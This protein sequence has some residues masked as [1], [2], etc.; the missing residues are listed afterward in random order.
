MYSVNQSLISIKS[1]RCIYV[2]ESNSTRVT[3]YISIILVCIKYLDGVTNNRENDIRP[4]AII[5]L[6]RWR[7]RGIASAV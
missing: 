3:L 5:Q 7:R 1:K 2:K 4:D 6:T